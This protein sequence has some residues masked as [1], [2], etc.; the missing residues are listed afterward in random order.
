[1]ATEIMAFEYSTDITK[2]THLA[3]MVELAKLYDAGWEILTPPYTVHVEPGHERVIRS[4][5]LLIRED[6]GN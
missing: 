3:S 1:M 5:V 2:A 4:Q 6:K